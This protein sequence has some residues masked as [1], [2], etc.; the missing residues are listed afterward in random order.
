MRAT[1][2][3]RYNEILRSS[4]TQKEINSSFYEKTKTKRISSRNYAL[5][6][7]TIKKKTIFCCICYEHCDLS[8]CCTISCSLSHQYCKDCLVKYIQHQIENGL[9]TIY[10]PESLLCSGFIHQNDLKRILSSS[11]YEKWKCFQKYRMNHQCPFCSHLLP[12]QNK[13]DSAGSQ[14]SCNFCGEYFCVYHSNAHSPLITCRQYEQN[15]KERDQVSYELIDKISQKCPSCQFPTQKISGCDSMKC[16][17][18]KK[19][20]DIS[21]LTSLTCIQRWKYSLT[22]NYIFPSFINQSEENLSR[23]RITSCILLTG[24]LFLIFILMS[25]CLIRSMTNK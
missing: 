3:R 18:C 24:L 21:E 15:L 4:R 20:S 25:F 6:N 2:S 13:E 10:C 22:T 1:S 7:Q 11:S 14:I 19:V 5:T 8:S 9:T 23:V 17:I 16:S 12:L